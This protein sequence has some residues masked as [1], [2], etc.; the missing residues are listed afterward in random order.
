MSV[1]RH[2]HAIFE[3]VVNFFGN[4][5]KGRSLAYHFGRD[6]REAGDEVR[7]F[8]ARID[9]CMKLV[10]D[11][12]TIIVIDRNL[13]HAVVLR[14]PSGGFNIYNGIHSAKLRIMDNG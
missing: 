7:D 10:R 6:A 12:H 9:E 4:V 3:P 8:A 13:R 1:V 11:L 2:K 14:I 5:F